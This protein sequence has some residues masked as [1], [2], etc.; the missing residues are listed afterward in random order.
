MPGPDSDP[1]QDAEIVLQQVLSDDRDAVVG[2]LDDVVHR[3]GVS[4]AF[5]LAVCLAATMVGEDVRRGSWTLEFPAIDDA[6]YDARWVAR[7]VSA[8]V[9]ADAPTGRALLGA[10]VADGQLPACLLALAGS[11]LATL[12]RRA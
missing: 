6:A 8:Y 2:T 4:G 7:F 12:R 10:A 5:D 11:A 1:Y 3:T 9:N